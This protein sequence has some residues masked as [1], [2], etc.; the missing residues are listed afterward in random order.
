M[1]GSPCFAKGTKVLTSMGYKNIEDIEIGDKVLTH[2]NRFKEVEKKLK[3]YK[4][5]M[6][7]YK[8]EVIKWRDKWH[9][10]R[11]AVAENILAKRKK[12][13]AFCFAVYDGKVQDEEEWISKIMLN[14]LAERI[15]EI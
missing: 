7:I 9:L 8:Q 12:E 4:E 10:D 6:H 1:H 5:D 14:K 3:T 2:K 15:D 13:S 11:K